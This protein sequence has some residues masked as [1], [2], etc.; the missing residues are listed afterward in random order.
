VALTR[1]RIDGLNFLLHGSRVLDLVLDPEE[2]SAVITIAPT[3]TPKAGP[4]PAKAIVSLL[5]VGSMVVVLRDLEG[6]AP[7]RGMEPVRIGALGSL[8]RQFRQPLAG[9]DFIDN[10]R[11]FTPGGQRLFEWFDA[12]MPG[13]EHTL[14][15]FYGVR[16]AEGA[17]AL[18]FFLISFDNARA[19]DPNGHEIPVESFAAAGTGWKAV[20]FGKGSGVLEP[21]TILPDPVPPKRVDGELLGLVFVDT[22]TDAIVGYAVG[23]ASWDG[24]SLRWSSSD[25]VTY[26]IPD[27]LA[28]QIRPRIPNMIRDGHPLEGFSYFS[29]VAVSPDVSRDSSKLVSHYLERSRSI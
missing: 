17:S 20:N 21:V 9:W 4:I 7:V 12:A 23:R 11:N 19:T 14:S 16:S 8:A 18:L 22:A 15:F 25:S 28:R 29:L 24:R 3:T 1:Q 26:D 13:S 5:P 2:R 6:N 10:E 27:G